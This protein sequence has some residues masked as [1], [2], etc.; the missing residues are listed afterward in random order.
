MKT[1]ITDLDGTL[2]DHGTLHPH[3]IKTLKKFQKNGRLILASGRSLKN[4]KLYVEQ[5]EMA[6]FQNGAL[7]GLNGLERYDFKTGTYHKEQGISVKEVKKIARSFRF[8]SLL[9]M[10][11][12]PDQEMKINTVFS[13]LLRFAPIKRLRQR[14][15]LKTYSN[16][17]E[18]IDKIIVL[19]YIGTKRHLDAIR[20]QF[21]AYQILRIGRF[22]IEIMPQGIDKQI[23]IQYF[24]K[25][26][27]ISSHDL[28]IFGDGEN[29][30][31]MLSL[32]QHSYAPSSALEEIKRTAK[33][34]CPPPA[35]EGVARV[36]ESLFD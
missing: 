19:F 2:L 29:D 24:M 15:R 1:I 20:R 31:N 12:L 21:K 30:R 14:S 17:N 13:F 36:I 27:A 8:N 23:Q 7:I 11:D 28:Y 32:T 3:T 25:Q 22:W 34:I 16:Q 26:Y 6:S 9:I 35:K 5:L 33:H 18:P 4:L 10:V